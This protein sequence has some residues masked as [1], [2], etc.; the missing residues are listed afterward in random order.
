MENME[1]NDRVNF[2]SELWATF[3][4]LAATAAAS[5]AV[6]AA[7]TGAASEMMILGGGPNAIHEYSD[8]GCCIIS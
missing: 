8:T 4:G 5:A 2:T 1:M 3:G 6:S 7:A